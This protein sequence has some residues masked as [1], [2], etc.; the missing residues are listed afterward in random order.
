MYKRS[1]SV[2]FA[3]NAS[4]KFTLSMMS[5]PPTRALAGA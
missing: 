4:N 5:I 1:M 2:F 3:P